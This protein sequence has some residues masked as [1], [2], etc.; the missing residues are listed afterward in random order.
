MPKDIIFRDDGIGSVP[1]TGDYYSRFRVFMTPTQ[2]LSLNP[3]RTYSVDSLVRYVE[4]TDVPTFAPGW[5]TVEYIGDPNS[6]SP[7]DYFKVI[8]HEGRGRAMVFQRYVGE[9]LIP[10][11]MDVLSSE[12]RL[13]KP[14]ATRMVKGKKVPVLVPSQALLPI[15]AEDSSRVPLSTLRVYPEMAAFGYDAEKDQPRVWE[16]KD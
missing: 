11:E 14:G 12:G 10:V 1:L 6:P 13:L 7:K 9:E 2:F 5:L 15:E 4:D 16:R 3:P 8:G